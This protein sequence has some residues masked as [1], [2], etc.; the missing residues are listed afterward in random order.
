VLSEHLGYI[1]NIDSP[2]F[3]NLAREPWHLLDRREERQSRPLYIVTASLLRACLAP[4]FPEHPKGVLLLDP[5]YAAFVVANFVVLWMAM[6]AFQGLFPDPAWPFGVFTT[7]VL[8]VA[9]DVVKLFFWTPHTQM[10]NVLAPVVAML[11]CRWLL[12]HPAIRASR[13]LILGLGLGALT[14]FYG[15]FLVLLPA[16]LAALAIARARA[17]LPLPNV[18]TQLGGLSIGFVIAPL[19]WILTVIALAGEF[20][21]DEI[22]RFSQFVWILRAW[23]AGILEKVSLWA[24]LQF[25]RASAQ[26]LAF[27]LALA[28]TIA[29]VARSVGIRPLE[30]VR[31]HGP[32]LTAAAI[33]FTA[34]LAFFALLGAYN[35]RLS[36]NLVPPVLAVAAGIGS[37]LRSRV[38]PPPGRVLDASVALAVVTWLAFTVAKRG[39]WL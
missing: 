31:E 10:F 21:S 39:P 27:P 34:E 29:F 11:S 19:A 25:V 18:L 24:M 35:P 5:A 33:T 26:A 16:T 38:R 1:E 4:L 32:T 14:L 12:S 9:N 23:R 6:L 3:V 28:G 30:V 37:T 13:L 2:R 22:G 8:L 7:S 17:T 20:Y 36:W 15:S